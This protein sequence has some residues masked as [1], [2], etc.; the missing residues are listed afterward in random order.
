[1]V[2][3]L[4]TFLRASCVAH[5]AAFFLFFFPTGDGPFFGK[6]AYLFPVFGPLCSVLPASLFARSPRMRRRCTRARAR[7]GTGPDYPYLFLP[8]THV[9]RCPRLPWYAAYSIR[10]MGEVFSRWNT[11]GNSFRLTPPQ[12][13][14]DKTPKVESTLAK[15]PYPIMQ[16][17]T[18]SISLLCQ[19]LYMKNYYV[20]FKS[21]FPD[22]ARRNGFLIIMVICC[23][24]FALN[25]IIPPALIL[26]LTNCICRVSKCFRMIIRSKL[27]EHLFDIIIR[28][29][30][31]NLMRDN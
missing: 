2:V 4:S 30:E 14:D 27:L 25:G 22:H 6:W 9:Y 7:A 18:K 5:M 3:A 12:C 16:R 23:V 1:M 26:S 8:R 28:L 19:F 17:N 11:R 10:R 21:R 20:R 15:Y 24:G 31:K 13:G 29:V